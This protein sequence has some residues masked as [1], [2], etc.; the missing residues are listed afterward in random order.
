MSALACAAAQP[1]AILSQPPSYG[2][3]IHSCRSEG[4]NGTAAPHVL[5]QF[6]YHTGITV[7]P[8]VQCCDRSRSVAAPCA[9][10][11]AS[12]EA[13]HERVI[14]LVDART[15]MHSL[16]LRRQPRSIHAQAERAHVVIVTVRARV[17]VARFGL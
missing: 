7:R 16:H 5:I 1:R 4:H 6:S 10:G 3:F 11:G 14:P 9:H 8:L 2:E 15:S 12:H 17:D 13:A